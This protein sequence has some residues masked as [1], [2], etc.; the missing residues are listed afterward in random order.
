MPDA[1]TELRRL[2]HHY[3][4]Q[5]VDGHQVVPLRVFQQVHQFPQAGGLRFLQCQHGD[6]ARLRQIQIE[7]AGRLLQLIHPPL[8]AD[9]LQHQ[10][11]LVA[12]VPLQLLGER[13]LL[14]DQLGGHPHQLGVSTHFFRIPRDA[15]DPEQL[16]LIGD[17]Q[18]DAGPH[19]L[20]LLGGRFAYLHHPVLGQR[21]HGPLVTLMEPLR[22]AGGD[23]EA[24]LVHHVDR[25]RQYL[26]G[27]ADNLMSERVIELHNISG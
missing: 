1:V 6:D 3:L 27:P 11:L 25:E 18:V 4:V 2:E 20:E 5:T 24:P 21:Q 7:E 9:E 10:F 8:A 23:D 14:Q 12:F 22:V 15:D 17:G 26:H 13:R 19:P 16:P